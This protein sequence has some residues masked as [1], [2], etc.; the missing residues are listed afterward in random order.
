MA[1]LA[2]LNV[3]NHY[4]TSYAPK[5]TTSFDT[6]K[7]SELRNIYNS[8]IKLNKESPL[9][10]LDNSADSKAFAIGLKENARELKNTISSLGGFDDGVLD[11][12]AF[13][14]KKEAYSGNEAVVSVSYIGNRDD[15]VFAPSLALEVH[16]LASPQVN[17]GHFIPSASAM[18]LS[19]DI[20]SFD[21]NINEL[22]YEFQFQVNDTDT[23]IDIQNRLMR[24]VNN[25]DIGID[26]EVIEDG[27]GNSS[28]KLTSQKNGTSEDRK[29]VF[30]ISDGQTSKTAGIVD[31]LG[32]D[33]VTRT[34]SNAEFTIDGTA[35]SSSSN[36]FTLE[37][38]YRITLNGISPE[39]S[40]PT[41]I[42]M[43]TDVENLTENLR[44]LAGG[45]NQFLRSAIEYTQKH[46]RSNQL[47]SEMWH[48]AGSFS[49]PLADIG[50][51]IEEDGS[52]K[53][54]ENM[55]QQSIQ[56]GKIEEDFEQ[57]KDFTKALYRKSG[58][59]SLNPMTYVEKTIVAY[60]NPGKN[61]ASPYITSAYSGMLFNSYC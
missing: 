13:L 56:N 40:A 8:I 24:L 25:A 14:N 23:N 55:L 33:N 41:T 37:K 5:G 16:S 21:L 11:E 34:P 32:I 36:T 3:Y 17:M 57:I 35:H 20:Y 49:E 22:N 18:E 54:D 39:G 29:Y 42:G 51:N 30:R 60:K 26:A 12:A 19:P 59:V 43:K 46:P 6:H 15:A 50:M 47:V 31:Y 44:H 58:Q 61:F 2:M 10:L 4:L 38:N 7:K 52:I 45:Y 1:D 53:I 48:L 9:Y 27:E 28:L